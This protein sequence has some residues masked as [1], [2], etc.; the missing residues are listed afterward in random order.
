MRT[1]NSRG[2]EFVYP[3]DARFEPSENARLQLPARL[4]SAE[5][6]QPAHCARAVQLPRFTC[7]SAKSQTV[8][9]D[10]WSRLEFA[11]SSPVAVRANEFTRWN[12]PNFP[13][14]NTLPQFNGFQYFDDNAG[15][16]GQAFSPQFG[17]PSTGSGSAAQ[18]GAPSAATSIRTERNSANC[19]GPGV[20]LIT[21]A[22]RPIHPGRRIMRT[23]ATGPS[24]G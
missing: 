2:F 19:S 7:R 12:D 21:S 23:L 8:Y 3:A 11:R 10:S 1:T 4:R 17:P 6:V 15:N 16:Y 18:V 22:I 5:R 20:G 13:M 24:T 14:T 9:D